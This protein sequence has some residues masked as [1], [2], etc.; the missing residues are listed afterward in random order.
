MSLTGSFRI[1]MQNSGNCLSNCGVLVNVYNI[2]FQ[3]N[4]YLL[5]KFTGIFREKDKGFFK[6]C[7]KKVGGFWLKVQSFFTIVTINAFLELN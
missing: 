3:N 2:I 1:L 6:V 5:L 4:K 7:R